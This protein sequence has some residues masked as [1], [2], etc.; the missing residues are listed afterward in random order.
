MED[1]KTKTLKYFSSMSLI[2]LDFTAAG[3]CSLTIKN[4]DAD[5]CGCMPCIMLSLYQIRDFSLATIKCYLV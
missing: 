4:I 2:R 3:H 1:P 5:V